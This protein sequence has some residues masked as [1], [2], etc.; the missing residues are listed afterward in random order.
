VFHNDSKTLFVW[1]GEEDHLRIV[2]IQG[3]R[4]E[5]SN[6]GK[7]MVECATR[8]FRAAGAVSQAVKAEGYDFMRDDHLGWITTCPFNVGTGVRAGAMVKL[9]NLS[10]RPDWK[11]LV[12][13]LGL[14]AREVGSATKDG[15]WDVS[16]ARRIGSG[17]VDLVNIFIEGC[18]QLVKWEGMYDN[19]RQPQADAEI[20]IR[21]AVV[22]SG[23]PKGDPGCSIC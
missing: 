18:A 22:I 9:P 21:K 10:S 5:P 11:A 8:L 19:D 13:A 14:Q 2:S 17:E 3:N 4:A 16:N 1:V 7:D 15:T 20:S 23:L 6:E 12:N